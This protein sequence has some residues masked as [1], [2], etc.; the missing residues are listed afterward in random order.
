LDLISL[1]A[2]ALLWMQ[3]AI[4]LC[5]NM[6]THLA[7]LMLRLSLVQ[8]ADRVGSYI[9]GA[10]TC[11]TLALADDLGVFRYMADAPPASSH[12]IAKSTKLH[13]RWVRE[14]LHQ[15]VR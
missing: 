3:R 14:L 8:I 7:L 11:L 1:F 6:F 2:T 13:E 4:I 5:V 10:F 9:G 15:L 12:A